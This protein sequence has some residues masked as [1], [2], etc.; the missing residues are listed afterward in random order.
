MQIFL[1]LTLLSSSLSPSDPSRYKARLMFYWETK[2]TKIYLCLSLASCSF[3]RFK[4]QN[5]PAFENCVFFRE[6]LVPFFVTLSNNWTFLVKNTA[7][8]NKIW[9]LVSAKRLRACIVIFRIPRANEVFAGLFLFW[10]HSSLNMVILCVTCGKCYS[11]EEM[12]LVS[13]EACSG[14]YLEI[15]VF[16]FWCGLT[17]LCFTYASIFF[18]VNLTFYFNITVDVLW[19]LALLPRKFYFKQYLSIVLK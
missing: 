16:Q 13:H 19:F 11:T 14:Q 3:S 6:T 9:R 17:W 15:E 1:N 7:K 2:S 4:I 18:G 8:Q 12:L 5:L 10:H